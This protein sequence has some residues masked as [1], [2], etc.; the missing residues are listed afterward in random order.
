M[1]VSYEPETDPKV[2]KGLV[3]RGHKVEKIDRFQS[4][5]VG[6]ERGDDGRIYANADFRKAGAV[7]GF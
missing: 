7:D 4:V 5:V 2:L 1:Q 6:I 3:K